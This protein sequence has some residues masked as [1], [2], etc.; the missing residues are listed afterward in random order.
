MGK[1][2]VVVVVVVVC[3][4]LNVNQQ[5][6]TLYL[7]QRNVMLIIN[8]IKVFKHDLIVL[9]DNYLMMINVNVWNMN[10]FFVELD[11]LI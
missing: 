8:V 5:E 10:E 6:F 11:Q 4:V 3:Q 2:V 9:N 1:I 7:I